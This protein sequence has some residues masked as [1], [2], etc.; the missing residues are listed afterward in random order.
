[1]QTHQWSRI[2]WPEEY[3][4]DRH[5]GG[6][7]LAHAADL[8]G[9]LKLRQVV[10]RC[11][12]V[13]DVCVTARHVVAEVVLRGSN[14]LVVWACRRATSATVLQPVNELYRIFA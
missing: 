14:D 5:V 7:D 9:F 11:P 3:A 4:I 6:H 2:H 13:A 10:L 12:A 1:M 8:D